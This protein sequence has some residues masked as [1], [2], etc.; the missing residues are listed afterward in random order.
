V[1]AEL[2]AE[3]WAEA[4]ERHLHAEFGWLKTLLS[5]STNGSGATS[6]RVERER[7]ELREALAIEPAIDTLA[8]AFGLTPFERHLLLLLAGVEMDGELAEL[9][10][11]AGG[12]QRHGAVTVGMALALLP[13]AHWS[14]L[15]PARPLRRWHLLE[16]GNGPL[17]TASTMR[18]DERVLHYLAGVDAP[19]PRMD[20]VLRRCRPGRLVADAHQ[21]LAAA[22][23]G[24]WEP[25]ADGWPVVQL[26]GG[27]RDGSED[28]AA[29]VAAEL[30]WE[31]DAVCAEHLPVTPIDRHRFA[32]LWTRESILRGAALLVEATAPS[33]DAVGELAGAIRGPLL[34]AAP[35]ALPLRRSSRA[36]PVERT[37]ERERRSLWRQSLGP[38]HAAR[39]G[40]VETLASRFALSARAIGD[41][42][43]AV[44]AAIA[45]GA[46]PVAAVRAGRGRPATRLDELAQR[47][48][49]VA[50]WKDLVVPDPVS[51]TLRAIAAQ[52]RH[53]ATVYEEWGF[54]A[55]GRRGLG[56]TALF[57]GESG[58]GKTMAAEVLANDLSLYLY[59]I[60]L[61]GVVSKYIGETEKNLAR[62]FDAAED[63]AILLFDEAD[64]LF[65]KRTE[66]RD[67]HDRY[68]NVEVSYLL[69]RMETYRGL[70]ILTT[71]LK[72]ALD[73]AF[74]R[75]L[76]FVAAFPFPDAALRERIWRGVFPPGTPVSRLDWSRLAGIAMSGGSIRNVAVNAAFLAADAGQSVRM[77][78][79]LQAA[80]TEFVK[81][82]RPVPGELRG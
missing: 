25:G 66:V 7:T 8:G 46:D 76:R 13:H 78:H 3:P 79:V 30:G 43:S 54:A 31:L 53:R 27:E 60:D 69:Q 6:A 16:L 18:V 56:I 59:V 57:T 26:H 12:P 45:A 36:Y 75:R 77:R 37:T 4:N 29:L 40:L 39:K 19:E 73:R 22:I 17:L 55:R 2:A 44:H 68:A 34:V 48:E 21:A 71:N 80:R 63:G 52:V 65:G 49:P 81:L 28:I 9:C 15:S 42:A 74:Q 14:A 58:T 38:R 62:V 41:S 82:E 51:D 47:V 23:A 5:D 10:V 61:S 20:G 1:I 67:S 64:A 24:D 72:T 70:A 35:E 11:V 33:R 32:T 50:T